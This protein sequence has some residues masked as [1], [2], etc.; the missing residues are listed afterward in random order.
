MYFVRSCVKLII[1][2]FS[3]LG[4]QGTLSGWYQ[5]EETAKK[6]AN[7]T[8]LWSRERTFTFKQLHDMACQWGH[9]FLS[10]GVKRGDVVAT[11]L[12][13]CL[14]FPVIW[15]GLLSIGCAPAFINYNL[16][17]PALIHC[18]KVSGA[19]FLIVDTDPDCAARINEQL[20]TIENELNL[21]PL[22]LDQSLLAHIATFPATAPPD[23]LR[24]G[25]DPMFPF[26]IFYTSGTTGL[27]KGCAF[28]TGRNF[29]TQVSRGLGE[30]P[31]DGGDR[32]YNCMP[33]YHGTGGMSLMLCLGAGVSV[34]L[35]KKFSVKN[36]W[37][38]IH[39]SQATYFI[40][41]GETARYLLAAPPSPLDRGH[42]VR[43]VYGNG[44][45]PDV[46][47]KFRE[48]FGI[49]TIAEFFSSSEG[50]FGLLNV[51]HGPYLARCVGHHGAIMRFLLRNTYAPSRS[52]RSPETSS[53]TR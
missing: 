30:R 22:M 48:R 49:E 27:P 46:W 2:L 26:C 31:G 40:Y 33:W 16:A 41:V 29:V 53:A 50:I 36:F 28:T 45:R 47:E 21:K 32:W 23:K 42:K 43:C 13:N 24:R 5:F 51:D 6:H 20:S 9:Y 44:L 8:A 39:D 38:D 25:V 4:A 12:Q 35:G 37:K 11:Y 15:F 17:G 3:I 19:E 18:L 1:F 34:A 7:S 10:L 52:I 14:E